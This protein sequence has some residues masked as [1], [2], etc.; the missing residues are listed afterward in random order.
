MSSTELA[1]TNG[2]LAIHAGQDRWDAYQ[3]A[4]LQQLGI[5]G[6]TNADL[7]VFLHYC[8]KTQLD[9]FSKQ[10]Y[11]IQ[12]Q[13]KWVIQTGIDGFRVVARRAARR[14]GE[15]L[16]YDDSLWC[17]TGGQWSDVWTGAGHPHAAK[18]VVRRDGRPF[19][20]VVRYSAFV[21]LK[22]G[23]PTGQ[24][25]RMDA[26]Q[27]EKCAEAKA[28]R[29]A[30]PHDLGGVY[31]PE[32]FQ[33]PVHPDGLLDTSQM[34]ESEKDARGLMTRHDRAE[35]TELR[36]MAQSPAGSVEVVSHVDQ[37][38]KRELDK[39]DAKWEQ[40]GITDEDEQRD[41]TAW[42]APGWT[43]STAQVRLVCSFLDDAVK[44]TQGDVE[45]ARSD[46][47]AQYREANPEASD[48]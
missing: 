23:R 30:F 16:E 13:G 27:L 32:E 18:V 34:S 38:P 36:R 29:R 35:H 43:A 42:L 41:L 25:E 44:N 40:I 10:V 31:L 14:D 33:A 24:W 17:D 47:W 21:P 15:A 28:L 3:L 4:A 39:L 8:Q 20:G 2:T 9:P 7:A 6:A 19:P 26:E 12:R 45:S 46:I 37:A 48:G 22:D 11:M 5:K 1:I